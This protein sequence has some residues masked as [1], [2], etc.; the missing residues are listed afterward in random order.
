MQQYRAVK[1]RYHNTLVLFRIGDFFELFEE[2]AETACRTLGLDLTSRDKS[3]IPMAGFPHRA[4]DDHLGRLVQAGHSVAVCDQVGDAAEEDG[5]V[6]RE[7]I[8]VVTP[9]TVLDDALLDPR[10]ANH[11]AA[12]WPHD[13]QIGLA[14]VDLSTGTFQTADCDWTRLVDELDRIDPSECLCAEGAPA[15]LD[16]LIQTA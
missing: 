3:S 12:I 8:R 7:V 10:R 1:E 14:W 4:L 2:D 5:L 16:A 6:R 15:R 13:E 9:G 11:L